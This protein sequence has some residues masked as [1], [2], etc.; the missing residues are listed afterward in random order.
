MAGVGSCAPLPAARK[1]AAAYLAAQDEP[2]AVAHF[3]AWRRVGTKNIFSRQ[4]RQILAEVSSDE[5]QNAAREQEFARTRTECKELRRELERLR[6][7]G[8]LS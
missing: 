6:M 7:A 1:H 5:A 4:L 8:G 3:H 2:A